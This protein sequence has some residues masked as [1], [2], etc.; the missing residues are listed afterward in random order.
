LQR[1]WVS[2]DL[3]DHR[4]FTDVDD[5][6]ERANATQYG[7]SGSLWSGSTERARALASRLDCGTVWINQHLVVVPAAPTGGHKWS[8]IGVENGAE[9]LLEFTQVQAVSMLRS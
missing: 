9:G 3:D 5:A 6:I 1:R 2:H 4:R 7:L 8:G